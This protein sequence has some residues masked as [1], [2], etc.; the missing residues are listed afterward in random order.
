LFIF[1]VSISL[2]FVFYVCAI[3]E[4]TISSAI[5]LF[6]LAYVADVFLLSPT[7]LFLQFLCV[8]I[9]SFEYSERFKRVIEARS[10][11]ILR[12]THGLINFFNDFVQHFN[13]A[14]RAARM[15]PQLSVSKMLM[16]VNDADVYVVLKSNKFRSSGNCVLKYAKQILFPIL[17]WVLYFSSSVCLLLPT[18]LWVCLSDLTLT[19][20]MGVVLYVVVQI[21]STILIL[22]VLSLYAFSSVIFILD[23]LGI[24]IA[25]PDFVVSIFQKFTASYSIPIEQSGDENIIERLPHEDDMT[26]R[27]RV[28]SQLTG[29]PIVNRPIIPTMQ[30]PD[31]AK[32]DV[33]TGNEVDLKKSLS[34]C[35]R[36]RLSREKTL[37]AV[38]DTL[39]QFSL[40][41][42]YQKHNKTKLKDVPGLL[43]KYK[44][45]RIDLIADLEMKYKRAF[46]IRDVNDFIELAEA[47]LASS[48]L[49]PT[50]PPGKLIRSK[51]ISPL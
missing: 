15:Y 39:F 25:I 45:R 33:K 13:P 5:I 31:K 21:Q 4:E 49:Q 42:F 19:Y 51:G 32:F 14:C 44:G 22:L 43:L 27:R 29:S 38:D 50:N 47:S 41:T 18:D 11:H 3:L 35:E 34:P 36:A 1:D 12:R 28:L 26:Y 10:K 2:F 30:S 20:G 7:R 9:L 24:E 37:E 48:S 6:V 46:V 23:S 40:I 16:A 17:K 8:D